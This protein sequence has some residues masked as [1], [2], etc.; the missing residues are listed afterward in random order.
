[1]IAT[2]L[3]EH[4]SKAFVQIN[5]QT[6]PN[7]ESNFKTNSMMKSLNEDFI[8]GFATSEHYV[9]LLQD[10]GKLLFLKQLFSSWKIFQS[11]HRQGDLAIY[12]SPDSKVL[13][14][15]YFVYV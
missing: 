11:V 3:E 13:N 4:C 9:K 10:S 14:P 6:N 2:A 15:L 7:L 1:M 12:L 5:I 8:A